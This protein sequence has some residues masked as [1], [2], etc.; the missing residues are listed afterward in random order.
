MGAL[1]PS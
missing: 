1:K